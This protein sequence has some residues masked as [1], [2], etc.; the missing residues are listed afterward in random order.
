MKEFCGGLYKLNMKKYGKSVS[1]D[2]KEL[3]LEWRNFHGLEGTIQVGRRSRGVQS[4]WRY[5]NSYN[6]ITSAGNTEV[7]GGRKSSGWTNN[8]P[9]KRT[10]VTRKVF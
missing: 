7:V 6:M 9:F 3:P 4:L 8:L 5:S 1:L 2:L 10:D